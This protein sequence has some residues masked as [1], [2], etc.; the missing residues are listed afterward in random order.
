MT[1]VTIAGHYY[2]P[3]VNGFKEI[4]FKEAME[5]YEKGEVTHEEDLTNEYCD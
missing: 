3:V 5:L 4:P 2:I 1:I